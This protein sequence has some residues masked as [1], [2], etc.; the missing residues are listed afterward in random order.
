MAMNRPNW[1]AYW[2]QIADVVATRS[3]CLSRHIGAVLVHDNNLIA[4]GYNGPP[5]GVPH[6]DHR[7]STGAYVVHPNTYAE[8]TTECP[9][10]RMGYRSGEGL[11]YC[12]AVHAERNTILNAA[13][14]GRSTLDTTL[15]C[16]CPALCV[17]CA[18][19][20]INAGVTRIVVPGELIAYQQGISVG[21]LLS[22]AKVR[23]EGIV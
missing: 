7:L 3:S 19:E 10:R 4:T 6:C 23:L 12:A 17:D 16:T 13:R 15:Y 22:Q 8:D 9:R 2:L 1:D 21:Q 18:K 14:L 11:E 5:R 20:L